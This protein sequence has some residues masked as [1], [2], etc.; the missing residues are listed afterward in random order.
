MQDN[1]AP[2]WRLPNG[3]W[4]WFGAYGTQA[5]INPGEELVTLLMIQNLNYEVQRDF[6]S[7]VVQALID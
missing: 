3:S 2:G 7:A 6:E 1:I 4:G 5:W